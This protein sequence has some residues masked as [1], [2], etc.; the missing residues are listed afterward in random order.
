MHLR[1]VTRPLTVTL[2]DDTQQV[3]PVGTVLRGC[4]LLSSKLVT[5]VW[6]SPVGFRQGFAPGT[7]LFD[8]TEPL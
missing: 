1:T 7:I 6:Q 8:S 4:T 3:V 2:G 5:F